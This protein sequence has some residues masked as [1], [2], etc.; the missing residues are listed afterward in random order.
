MKKCIF[1]CRVFS[2]LPLWFNHYLSE[3]RKCHSIESQD[4]LFEYLEYTNKFIFVFRYKTA[5]AKKPRWVLSHYG[6]FKNLWDLVRLSLPQSS[7]IMIIILI[8]TLILLI[9]ISLIM[10]Y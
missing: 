6:Y 2:T 5:A 3:Y 1:L 10:T 4:F 9:P 7:I 8:L